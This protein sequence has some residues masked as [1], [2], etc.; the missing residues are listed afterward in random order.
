[1]CCTQLRAV[2]DAALADAVAAM[3]QLS[4][5]RQDQDPD[6]AARAYQHCQLAVAHAQRVSAQVVSALE[7]LAAGTVELTGPALARLQAGLDATQSL[8]AATESTLPIG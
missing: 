4:A 5:A 6:A 2:Q 7:D 3:Q 8:I 1:V